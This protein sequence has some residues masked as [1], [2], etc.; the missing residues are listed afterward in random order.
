[1]HNINKHQRLLFR[2]IIHDIHI[3][4]I[5]CYSENVGASMPEKIKIF[6]VRPLDSI[7]ISDVVY[8]ATNANVGNDTICLKSWFVAFFTSLWKQINEYYWWYLLIKNNVN[9]TKKTFN[10]LFLYSR[11]LLQLLYTIPNYDRWKW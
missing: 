11:I 4:L 6:P 8:D 2:F 5:N 1:M 10:T 7:C 3:N 9:D